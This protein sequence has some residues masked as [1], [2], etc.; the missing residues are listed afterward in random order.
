MKIHATR[1][2]EHRTAALD[3]IG[4]AAHLQLAER[5]VKYALIAALDADD[6]HTAAYR[7]SDHGAYG[8]IHTRSV[9]PA[10]QYSYPFHN[11]TLSVC[12]FITI[13]MVIITLSRGFCNRLTHF[14]FMRS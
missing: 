11:Q 9:A 12:G 6:A 2:S 4:Y 3:D 1:R 13:P 8:G 10:S 7:R 14:I 5:F